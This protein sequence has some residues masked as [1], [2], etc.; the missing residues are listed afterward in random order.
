MF[1][2]NMASRAGLPGERRGGS[3]GVPIRRPTDDDS[4]VLLWLASLS[5]TV[6]ELII[7]VCETVE[8]LSAYLFNKKRDNFTKIAL[9]LSEATY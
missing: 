4:S 9:I 7:V 3:S 5:L 1:S 2:W 8:E 6:G